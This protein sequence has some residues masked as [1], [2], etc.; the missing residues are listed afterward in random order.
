M[1]ILKMGSKVFIYPI[2]H[3][4]NDGEGSGLDAD[5]LDGKDSSFF[6][7]SQ[8]IRFDRTRRSF[9]ESN[10]VQ[11]AIDELSDNKIRE[12]IKPSSA[13]ISTSEV[14]GNIINNYGQT[15]DVI[16]SLPNA[17]LGQSFIVILSTT[18]NKYFR[19][20]AMSNNKIY[21]NGVPGSAGGY[22]G[23]SSAT[24]GNAIMFLSFYSGI[25]DW[26]GHWY[27]MT[28]SGNWTAGT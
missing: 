4:G 23:V 13:Y 10:S 9:L 6:L 25:S 16:L 24:A 7:D 21:L 18:V 19:I 28:M 8:N 15:T 14:K 26:Y 2:W 22:V 11:D 5:L 3:S 27:A 20:K 17:V 1:S 12:V